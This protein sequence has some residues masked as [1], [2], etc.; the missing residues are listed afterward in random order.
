M[1]LI[2]F[3]SFCSGRKPS[4]KQSLKKNRSKIFLNDVTDKLLINIKYT[5]GL[6][7]DINRTNNA[8]KEMGRRPE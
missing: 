4:I 1:V 7:N 6:Y 2:K 8:V 3:K 5:I